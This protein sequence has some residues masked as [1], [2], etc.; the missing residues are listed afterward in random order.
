MTL[1]IIYYG[2]NLGYHIGPEM[3]IK[4]VNVDDKSILLP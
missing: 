4:I 2:M 1:Y 3:P